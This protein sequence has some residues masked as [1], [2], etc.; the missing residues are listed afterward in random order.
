M[1]FG[2]HKDRNAIRHFQWIDLFQNNGGLY[3]VGTIYINLRVIFLIGR[4]NLQ[5][6]GDFM[7]QYE[8]FVKCS[9]QVLE[10]MDGL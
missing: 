1:H 5:E 6:T 10:G 8:C 3:D 2:R 9:H 4:V 7:T